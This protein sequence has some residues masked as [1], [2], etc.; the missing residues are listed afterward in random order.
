MEATQDSIPRIKPP[1]FP[2]RARKL[3][4]SNFSPAMKPSMSYVS[5]SAP[6]ALRLSA[7]LLSHRCQEGEG[8]RGVTIARG[9]GREDFSEVEGA[10]LLVLRETLAVCAIRVGLSGTTDWPPD[11]AVT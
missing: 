6:M 9:R 7:S 8:L 2:E 1:I 11:E 4:T 10:E 5:I 3:S